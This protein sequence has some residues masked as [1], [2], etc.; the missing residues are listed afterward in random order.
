MDTRCQ[1][2]L[3][4]WLQRSESSDGVNAIVGYI[5]RRCQW[6]WRRHIVSSVRTVYSGHNRCHSSLSLHRPLA[7]QQH[8]INCT[9]RDR[10]IEAATLRSNNWTTQ[11]K[12]L[13]SWLV[14]SCDGWPPHTRS[15]VFWTSRN[16]RLTLYEE[17]TAGR[18]GH[19]NKYLMV[20]NCC[21]R[22]V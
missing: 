17:L 1:S 11:G 5:T 22:A 21:I 10:G 2:N 18:I 12:S 19:G 20:A 6:S 4:S 13:L 8:S 15:V 14:Y 16:Q 9:R 3:P 7:A